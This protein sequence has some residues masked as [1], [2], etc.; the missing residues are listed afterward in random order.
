MPFLMPTQRTEC[1]AATCELFQCQCMGGGGVLNLRHKKSPRFQNLWKLLLLILRVMAVFSR[2]IWV[3]QSFSSTCPGREPLGTVQQGSSW[4]GC[5]SC[6]PTITEWNIK[7]YRIYSRTSRQ[8]LAQFWRS[9]CGGRLIRGS[10]CTARVD[11]QHDGY[12][13]ATHT[14][15]EPHMAWTI[16]KSLGLRG[17]VGDSTSAR[18]WM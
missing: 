16:S 4:A 9:C 17:C 3:S 2:W 1:T 15:F 18:F 12:L 14:V 8:F 10:C 5:P 13:S 6:H 11:S 7:H